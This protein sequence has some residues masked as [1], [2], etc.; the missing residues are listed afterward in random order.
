MFA[1][2][3]IVVFGALRVKI[4][5]PRLPNEEIRALCKEQ[6]LQKRRTYRLTGIGE[7]MKKKRSGM[8]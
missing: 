5:Y 7:P 1:N 6:Y 2:S 8:C 4:L 3:D